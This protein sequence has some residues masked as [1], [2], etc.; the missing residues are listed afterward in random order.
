MTTNY[1]K[2]DYDE[3]NYYVSKVDQ[4]KKYLEEKLKNIDLDI[5]QE[6]INNTI[7]ESI[8]NVIDEEL[9]E[10][11]ENVVKESV[12]ISLRDVDEQFDEINDTLEEI[13]TLNNENKTE[14]VNKIDDVKTS[15]S[16]IA[17]KED[18]NKAI[19]EINQHTKERFDEIDFIQQFSNLNEQIKGIQTSGVDSD[20]VKVLSNLTNVNETAFTDN[21]DSDV[22]ES[23]LLLNMG[24]Y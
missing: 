11:I 16:D 12:T 13:K 22:D 8:Q 1:K 21:V 19:E 7:K 3:T 4:V 23:K 15:L 17:T 6:M 18:V 5:D 20:I 24:T 9:Q 10:S 14:I 2:Y